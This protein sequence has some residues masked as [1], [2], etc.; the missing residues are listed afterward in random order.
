MPA[1]LVGSARQITN[2]KLNGEKIHKSEDLLAQAEQ[3]ANLGSW[4]WDL[5]TGAIVWSD[6]MYRLRGFAPREVALTQEFCTGL[7]H[8]AD[9]ERG[10]ELLA[11]AIAS[12][13]SGQH[14]FRSAI[15]DGS[16]RGFQAR[17]SAV[18]SK[19]GKVLRIVGTTQDITE[20]KLAEEKI[21][22]SK[23]LLDQAEQ[24]ANL[25]SWESDLKTGS[26]TWS[27]N[28]YRVHGFAPGEVVPSV[29]LC[30]Q[31]LGPDDRER[32]GNLVAQAISSRRSMEHE[33]SS[34]TKDGLIR[35]HLTRFEPFVSESGEAVRIVGTTQDITERKLAEE[36]T[37]KSETLLR[38]LS[39]DL[40]QAQDTERRQIARELHESAGQ[41]LAALKMVLA[42]L[43]D[44]VREH[45]EEAW[46]HLQAVRG[47]ADDAIREIRVV[48]Y[49]M[50]PPMLD[51]VGLGPTIRWYARGFSERSGI[52]TTL[53]V[54]ERI[55]RLPQQVETT[56]FRIVQEALINIHRYAG[57]RTATVRL[58]QREDELC[59]EIQDQGC[60]LPPI[61][62]GQQ[63][64]L[65][66]GIAGMRERVKQLNGV[67]EIDSVAG[68]GTTVRA[69][70]PIA[71]PNHVIP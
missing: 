39:Q 33:Y 44:A 62:Q 5:E 14:E 34:R 36:K 10:K 46:D 53:E 8:P 22:K 50:H 63:S 43:E 29:E 18:V 70:L 7:L 48:S 27:D 49:L 20:R 21:K 28:M 23:T 69:I 37:A 15:K 25:G 65:G 26:M 24:L 32:A 58:R 12:G 2:R 42:N 31:M 67:F 64:R 9:R 38:R 35:T 13:Q 68:Q 51:E 56:V 4:E 60:G 17:F 45:T 57:C 54:D 16:I 55:E 66:V 30:L 47:L 41:T 3:L 6:N 71:P 61:A 11:Q 52:A 19:S 59:V 1:R 40:I